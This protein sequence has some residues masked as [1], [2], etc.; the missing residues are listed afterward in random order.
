MVN[1]QRLSELF[2]SLAEI[3]SESGGEKN[4]CLKI[5]KIM[6][7]LGCETIIDDA[8]KKAGSDTGNL[9]AK[10][11]GNKSKEPIMLNAHMDTVKPGKG[12]KV[13][14]KDGVFTSDGT[15][16]LGADDKSAIAILI[17]ALRAI[18]ENRLACGPIEFVFTISEEIGLWGA[19]YLNYDLISSKYGYC[20]D[21][22][23][24]YTLVVQAP[25]A[26]FLQFKIHGKD[27]HAGIEPE[28]GINAVLIAS[29]A[30]ANLKLGRIDEETTCNIGLIEG[31][32][33][34]NI[35]PSYV[36][37]TGEARSHS[38]IK[39]Q[40]ISDNIID[41]FKNTVNLFKKNHSDKLPYL[42]AICEREFFATNCDISHKIVILAQRAAKNLGKKIK[43]ITTG[44]GADANIFFEKGII[45][46]VLGTGMKDIHTLR[47]S[48]LV[49][50]M[51]ETTE[52]L[53]EILKIS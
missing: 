20:L 30:I 5:K 38:A 34:P 7:S 22:K 14:L 10:F 42:E 6:E 2:K 8:S 3:D 48:I 12:V 51:K 21:T 52:L 23:D 49:E 25:G 19:K 40:K 46:G 32:K 29:K 26:N 45:T 47:E 44:G 50:D 53:L 24:I 13:L 15:T 39:L 1:K 9:I 33:A 4:I 18:V 35:V 43:L 31:G 41:I 17:E 27:A 16:V 11:K 28:K 36:V 37:V